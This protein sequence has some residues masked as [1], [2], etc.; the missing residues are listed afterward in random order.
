MERMDLPL[1]TLDEEDLLLSL[2]AYQICGQHPS[3]KYIIAEDIDTLYVVFSPS[4]QGAADPASISLYPAQD[5]V[6]LP[7]HEGVPHESLE[8]SSGIPALLFL[9]LCRERNKKNL[10]LSGC[11]EGGVLASLVMLQILSSLSKQGKLVLS[12]SASSASAS[13]S[14]SRHQRNPDSS[15]APASLPQPNNKRSLNVKEKRI[16]GMSSA[17]VSS[18]FLDVNLRC[19]TFGPTFVA[20]Q[21]LQQNIRRMRWNEVRHPLLRF[22]LPFLF[23]RPLSFFFCKPML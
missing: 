22:S 19:V 7:W 23:S 10:V 9:S 15:S 5:T 8:R 14:S 12:P 4:S 17:S 20:D 1:W 6:S 2:S 18:C 13:D 16:G 3:R 11:R 21:K